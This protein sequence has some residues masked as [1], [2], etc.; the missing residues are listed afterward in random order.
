MARASGVPDVQG[1]SGGPRSWLLPHAARTDASPASPPPPPHPPPTPRSSPVALPPPPLPPPRR[2]PARR[3]IGRPPR[4]SLT[5]FHRRVSGRP[6]P[7]RLS[8]R[9]TRR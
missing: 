8:R 1:G 7:P 2:S 4:G 5:H 3:A 6:P 9:P